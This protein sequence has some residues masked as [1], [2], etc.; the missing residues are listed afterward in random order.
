MHRMRWPLHPHP[1]SEESLL[2]WLGRVAHCY[3]FTLDDLL[4]H[5]LGFHG[6]PDDLNIHAPRNLLKLLSERSGLSE[7][8]IQVLTLSSWAP[9][10]FDPFCSDENYFESYVHHYSL[11][12][13]LNIRKKFK[14]KQDW[15]PWITDQVIMFLRACPICI[16]D[17][18]AGGHRQLNCF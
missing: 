5:D 10:L 7:E 16:T 11:L 14:P 1:L 2:S 9:L 3:D 12:L 4:I 13:P 8:N 17:D 18:P 15:K 6:C